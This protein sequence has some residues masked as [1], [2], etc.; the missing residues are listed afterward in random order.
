MEQRI[1]CTKC[2]TS[3]LLQTAEKTE[4]L[5]K[6]CYYQATGAKPVKQVDAKSSAKRLERIVQRKFGFVCDQCQSV[7][8]G[9]WKSLD[10]RKCRTCSGQMKQM[11][12]V[13]VVNKPRLAYLGIWTGFATICFLLW[14][15]LKPPVDWENSGSVLFLILASF[16]LIV[17]V[18][19]LFFV[20]LIGM[21]GQ[22]GGWRWLTRKDL[23][24]SPP[25]WFQSPTFGQALLR[26]SFVPL[27]IVILI[28][29][30][31]LLRWLIMG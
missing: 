16:G 23:L 7:E 10:N 5:C 22:S 1:N 24:K 13:E 11:E 9:A 27:G 19:Y 30:L 4:G 8:I 18:A 21:G 3:I 25:S 14:A 17:P 31:S 28:L 12:L 2:G 15:L 29:V 20:A 26:E 6:P